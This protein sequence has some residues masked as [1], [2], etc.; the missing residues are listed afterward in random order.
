[1]NFL[2][3][4]SKNTQIQNFTKIL[5]VA[6]EL[7]HAEGR[8]DGQADVTKL[9]VA[10]VTLTQRRFDTYKC[11]VHFDSPRTTSYHFLYL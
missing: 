5:P 11:T 10:V 8:T 3:S 4:S 2:D 1:L 9:I 6:A 7:L